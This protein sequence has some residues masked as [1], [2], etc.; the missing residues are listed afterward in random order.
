MTTAVRL[1]LGLLILLSILPLFAHAAGT[2]SNAFTW[3]NI[4]DNSLEMRLH[5]TRC[6]TAVGNQ[7]L[8]VTVYVRPG[9]SVITS[10]TVTGTVYKPQ[11][12]TDNLSFTSQG[13][14]NYSDSYN[15]SQTGTYKLVLRA[16][17]QDYASDDLN[18]Y[19]YAE[20]FNFNITFSNN[21]FS[22]QAGST[23]TVQNYVS[24]SD[25]NAVTGLTGT[26]DINYPNGTAFVSDGTI[27]ETGSGS[28]YYSFT[29][30]STDGVYTASS[31]FT[32]GTNTDTN[33]S[34]RFTVYGSGG[35]TSTGGTSGSTTT[36]GS[37]GGGGGGGASSSGKPSG[38]RPFDVNVLDVQ[39]DPLSFGIGDH[40]TPRIIF[41]NTGNKGS[42]FLLKVEIGQATNT[43]Y[44]F[45]DLTP[46][47]F[48]K[49][50]AE[51]VVPEDFSPLYGGSHTVRVDVYTP[52]GSVL[53]DSFAKTFHA[54]GLLRF[55][56][57]ATCLEESV[58]KGSQA[59]ARFN[60]INLGDYFQ[61]IQFAWWADSPRE[62][63]IGYGTFP[64]ALYREESRSLVRSVTI[65]EDASVGQYTFKGELKI[66]GSILEGQC[67]FFVQDDATFFVEKLS[68]A[69][70]RLDELTQLSS[71]KGLASDSAIVS[72]LSEVRVLIGLLEEAVS[73]NDFD[74]SQKLYD[75]IELSFGE[76]SKLIQEKTSI[77]FDLILLSVFTLSLVI[78]VLHFARKWTHH[79]IHTQKHSPLFGHE[80]HPLHVRAAHR[81]L[82][83]HHAATY[84]AAGHHSPSHNTHSS[85]PAAHHSS[86]AGKKH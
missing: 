16:T 8:N 17:K 47:I 58:R 83:L 23:G 48:A 15:F 46:F 59:S 25:N 10:A 72:K 71:F 19:V 77:P 24:N 45:T 21:Q 61:D 34:G 9:S 64:L 76:I 20:D 26:I 62:E 7:D 1:V 11:G 70:T 86:H 30:P 78:A 18:E 74:Q 42:V 79:T 63:K 43:Y 27:S 56:V 40:T 2:Q 57:V 5:A 37:S 51:F 28:Y 22:V 65:P 32:C 4:P 80:K 54:D 53:L 60:L 55:D 12:G 68:Y 50:T 69:R 75:K 35:G 6:M 38:I 39:F 84:H 13:D 85:H 29:A 81:V 44:F 36:G 73:E 66:N 52:D 14:G 82:G 3:Y 31:S 49:D 41:A 33:T 67:S